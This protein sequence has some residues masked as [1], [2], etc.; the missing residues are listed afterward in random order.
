MP[1]SARLLRLRAD[2]AALRDARHLTRPGDDPGPAGR[3]YRAWR[4]LAARPARL[5]AV[6]VARLAQSLG[7]AD[8]ENLFDRLRTGEGS[9]DRSQ[10]PPRWRPASRPLPHRRVSKANFW[11]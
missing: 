7:L 11:G 9:S 4:N 3:L 5:E 6:A 1:V 10:R 8:A 2:E